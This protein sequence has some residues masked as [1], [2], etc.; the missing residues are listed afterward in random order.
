MS[1]R[2]EERL[3]VPKWEWTSGQNRW[4]WKLR[5][6]RMNQWADSRG[7]RSYSI[8]GECCLHVCHHFITLALVMGSRNLKKLVSAVLVRSFTQSSHSSMQIISKRGECT[9]CQLSCV[10]YSLLHSVAREFSKNM[11]PQYTKWVWKES[12]LPLFMSSEH[13]KE[14]VAWILIPLPIWFC[15]NGTCTEG[16]FYIPLP[17]KPDMFDIKRKIITSFSWEAYFKSELRPHRGQCLHFSKLILGSVNSL[18]LHL[19]FPHTHG[20]TVSLNCCPTQHVFSIFRH[21]SLF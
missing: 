20:D 21:C 13:C 10:V 15:N 8:P 19:M 1:E 18:K 16:A 5:V 11:D 17:F 3:P 6:Y 9:N 14:N 4:C 2:L 7:F 12:S